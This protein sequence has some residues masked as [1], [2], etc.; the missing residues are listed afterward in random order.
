MS[1]FVKSTNT[2]IIPR[3]KGY[4]FPAEWSPHR[5]TWLTLPLNDESWPGKMEIIY[6]TFFDFVLLISGDEQACINVHTARL[7]KFVRETSIKKG[8]D[9]QKLEIYIHPSNDCWC[10]DHGPAFLVNKN[11]EKLVVDWQYNGWGNKY[12]FELDNRV[13]ELVSAAL[14][15]QKIDVKMVME[16]G[17]VDFNGEG[18]VLTTSSC[19]L[20][21]NRNPHLSRK[22]IENNLMDFYGVEQILWL[23]NGL[24]GD[25]TDG[26]IDDIT[27]FI[28]NDTV[29]TAIE[30]HADD[31]N[32]IPLKKNRENLSR[33]RLKNGKQLNIIEIPLPSPLF[34]GKDRL[35]AS[36]LNFY[37]TNKK[38]IVPLFNSSVD[39]KALDIL[40]SCFPDRNVVG[41]DSRILVEG[42]GSFH[43]LSQQEPI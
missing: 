5:A 13:P 21:Q 28:S 16:G 14:G 12:A 1:S 37:I 9:L 38:V 26:H 23:E 8:I 3:E 22:N 30:D 33:M 18:T 31:I 4:F 7:E 42:S 2:A 29:V 36:Y 43:C 35:P 19:L 15:L 34:K 6:G 41:I 32:Y 39:E 10:R 27:R 25:D 40:Q 17:S 11:G 20:N 24:A